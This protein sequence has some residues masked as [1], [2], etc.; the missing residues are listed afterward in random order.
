[1]HAEDLLDEVEPLPFAERRRRLAERGRAADPRDLARLL[2]EL[3]AGGHYERSTALFVAAAVRD[4]ASL[5]HIVR[6]ARDP[7]A[8]LAA[9]AVDLAARYGAAA[10]VFEALLADAPAAVRS[11]VYRA[12]RRRRRRDV[13]ERLIDAVAERWGEAEAAALLP[14]CGEEAARARLDGL[15]H[16]VPNWEAFARAHPGV[17]LD[18]AERTLPDVPDG[19]LSA[20][21]SREGAGVGAAVPHAPGRVL[22]LLERFLPPGP[23]PDGVAL[24]I[25]LLLGAE[26]ERTLRLLLS[27]GHRSA[28]P[29]LLE[30]S[31]VRKRLAACDDALIAEIA[32]AVRDDR[33]VLLM[34]LAAIAPSRREAV[35]AAVLPDGR[36]AGS[37]I[38]EDLLDLLP[39][40]A[41]VR[42]ARRL[43]RL[44]RVADR[45]GLHRE[46][47]SFLP[48]EEALPVLEPL[49]RRPDGDDRAVGYRLLIRCA[50]RSRDPRVL[51]R[52]FEALGR[53][54]NEQ[55]LIRQSA[56][57]ALAGVPASVL[58]AEHVPAVVRMVEDALAARDTS[59]RTRREAMLLAFRLAQQ[60]AMRGD[61]AL[62][63]SA[64]QIMA[65][66]TGEQGSL[67][68]EEYEDE[69]DA[70]LPHGA[71]HELGRMLAPHL[72]AM[73]RRND[74]ELALTLAADLHRRAFAVPELQDALE[75]ALDAR[76]DMVIRQ[77]IE[78]WL[79]V[80]GARR[81]RVARLLAE[82]PSAITVPE[83]FEVV[84]RERTDLLHL[85]LSGSPAGR[86]HRPD[87]PFVP[88]ARPSWMR[89]WTGRQCA[90][91][92]A[93]LH[94]LA[95]D[96]GVPAG[97]RA[98][99]VR[100]IA[101][102]PG[103]GAA[104][105][106][107]YLDPGPR[108]RSGGDRPLLRPALTAAPWLP[109]PQD[110][111]ADLL[112]FADSDDAHVALSAA[113]RAARF[114]RPSALAG[115]LRPVL[116]GGKIT[117]RKAALRILLRNRVPG[118]MELVA[119]AWDDPDQ[120]RDMRTAIASAVRA[121]PAEPAAWRILGE[122]AAAGGDLAHQVLGV[123]PAHVEERFRE[124]YAALVL[125]A[126]RSDDREVR[127]RS[128]DL[129][130]AWA[131][132]VP[133]APALLARVVAD[134][135]ETGSWQAA[136]RGLVRC[137][138]AGAG[139]AELAGAADALRAAPAEPDAG[140]DR[141][142]PA[143]RRLCKLAAEVRD[144]AREDLA[145][146]EPVLRALDG[147]LPEPLAAKL[148]AGT[149]RWDAPD[150]GAA[151]DALA[152]RPVGGVLAVRDVARALVPEPRSDRWY[153][154]PEPKEPEPEQVL[155]HALR[156][157]ARGDVTG[158]LFACA[159]AER[160]GRR[161]GW[162]EQWRDLLR[163]L[164]AHPHP[165]VTYAARDIQTAYE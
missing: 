7:D 157:A 2:D 89:R 87:V 15:A 9:R 152:D 38:D 118:A 149:L 6:A 91:Y 98:R 24:R 117:A 77:A 132:W 124:R 48:Y 113:A 99:A 110:V 161:A 160:H 83:V 159:L 111:L 54:R 105:L 39:R 147:R 137:A 82:E 60:G 121:R 66:I 55:N 78:L 67:P 27:D 119:A 86:F 97:E 79:A 133:Q 102:V 90:D 144:A 126:A 51:T 92:L 57:K 136:L 156:L 109:R 81:E 20:W 93:L 151:L 127:D 69:V 11:A 106:R 56:L 68:L 53:L 31:C 139:A 116:T 76:D 145:R 58:R 32:R 45:P 129:L 122:A 95:G 75:A 163:N 34:L 107:R 16:A 12:V 1:M 3:A 103:A 25:G 72:A 29:A 44:P 85:A 43:L 162:P 59:F 64:V 49:T 41:R 125:E 61:A 5:A 148:I 74:H 165:D 88:I 131:P 123:P 146:A 70:L 37:G 23:L 100:T 65:R 155:P 10:E 142:L 114:V 19:L 52:L 14:A 164:R 130:P 40:S 62:L 28:L 138:M 47:T 104:D 154:R 96:G 120:H 158:G 115:A 150:V 30:R 71:E 63:S 153:V 135:D 80:P 18:R 101:R 112:R 143:L 22:T 26:P 21:W 13:A 4:E 134:L 84:A 140:A 94:R 33:R 36:P 17:L 46:A 108:S 50:G 35:V 8:D 128:L 42:E 73:A 141:D